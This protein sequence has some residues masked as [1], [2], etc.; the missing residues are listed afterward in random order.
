LIAQYGERTW[1]RLLEMCALVEMQ[2]KN[3]RIERPQP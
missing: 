3:L 1:N 2:G